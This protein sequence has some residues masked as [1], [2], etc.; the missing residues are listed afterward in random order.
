MRSCTSRAR[1]SAT[2]S[3][4]RSASSSCWRAARGGPGCSRARSPG[5]TGSRACSC[6]P[7]RSVTTATA[8]TRSS[9]KTQR[10]GN[11][12]GAQVCVAWEDATDAGRRRGH[13]RRAHA[14]RSRAREAGRRAATNAVAVQAR[15]RWSSRFRQAVHELDRARRRHLRDRPSPQHRVAVRA[16]EPHRTEPGHATASSPRRSATRCTDP[17]SCRRRCSGSRS[18]TAASSSTRCSG[19]S[20]CRARSCR[21]AGSSSRTRSSTARSTSI[22]RGVDVRLWIDTDIGDNPDDAVALLCAAAHPDVE[23]VGVSTTG[24][25]T[26]VAGRARPRVR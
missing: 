23:L 2:R 1:G 17:R 11:D 8:A 14:H 24:G 7:R 4:H 18:C 12:F 21:R 6:R 22:L 10:P 5:S 20:A 3:G 25:R 19:A 13:P 9:P 15:D 16:G 26:R